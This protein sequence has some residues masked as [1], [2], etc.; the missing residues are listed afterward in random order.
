[1]KATGR[2]HA[3]TLAL[4]LLKITEAAEILHDE[5]NRFSDYKYGDIEAD[6][7]GLRDLTKQ[8][9]GVS[10]TIKHKINSPDLY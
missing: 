2:L 8:L 1:M 5:A 6:K 3:P 7:S 10:E 9:R 4:A